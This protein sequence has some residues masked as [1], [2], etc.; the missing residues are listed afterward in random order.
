VSVITPAGLGVRE[1]ISGV[2]LS[3]VVE[4][5]YHSLIPLVARLW[6]TV[7]ELGTIGLVLLS[8]GVK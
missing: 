4:S 2:L 1:G 5:P 3:R 7:A 6:V 8:R